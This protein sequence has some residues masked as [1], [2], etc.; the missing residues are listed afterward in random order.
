MS[1]KEL[2]GP[3]VALSRRAAAERAEVPPPA[4]LRIFLIIPASIRPLRVALFGG[5]C[6]LSAYLRSESSIPPVSR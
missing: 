4:S 6:L 3:L 1:H 5:F 2:H